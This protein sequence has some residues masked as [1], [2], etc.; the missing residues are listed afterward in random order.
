M[1]RIARKNLDGKYFHIM[2]QGTVKENIFH[3]DDTK[4]YYLSRMQNTAEKKPVV[5]L[6]FCMM[7]NHAHLLLSA[8]NISVIAQYMKLV[9]TG[10]AKHYNSVNQRSGSVFRD[11][12]KSE[13][14]QD[15][16]YLTN[17]LAYIHNNPVKAKIVESA[18]D[19]GYSSY[20]NYLT[21]S[22]IVNF[23]EA[24]KLYDISPENITAI[25]KEK[26]HG[27]WL[28]HDDKIYEKYEAVLEE[29]LKRYDVSSNK[30]D[31]D[32]L[33]KIAA[34]LNDRTGLSFRKIANILGVARENLR[35]A[36]SRLDG[37]V[38]PE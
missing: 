24:K 10:Y 29:L 38:I 37:G 19:Y 22:G 5:I 16:K 18:Q 32:I 21:E 4:G 9:N 31:C 36:M 27:A 11:R 13:I 2:V 7:N 30:P 35:R 34:E 20:M 23:Q 17:C 14:I 3:G 25:M 15:E 12:F 8:E 1:A 28:E 26:S 33:A 6:G